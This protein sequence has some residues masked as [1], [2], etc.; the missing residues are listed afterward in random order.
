V[1]ALVIASS[2]LPGKSE[3]WRRFTQ[4]MLASRREE[5]EAS[6]QQLGITKELMWLIQT[7]R[8]DTVIVY[9]ETE[10]HEHVMAKLIA[11]TLPFDSWFKRQILEIHGLNLTQSHESS[12]ELVFAWHASWK[13]P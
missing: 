6:R 9:L 3:A 12:K 2:I 11:S 10:E 7:S 5:Y 1:V 13:T 8:G 4:E